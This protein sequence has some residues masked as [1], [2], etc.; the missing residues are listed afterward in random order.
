MQDR[1]DHEHADEETER[2]P[3]VQDKDEPRTRPD[4]PTPSDDATLVQRDAGA[5][6]EFSD[7]PDSLSDP[8]PHP[9]NDD[10]RE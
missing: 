5:N 9:E 10:E 7:A 3:A 6:A 4:R 2:P 1:A 8:P